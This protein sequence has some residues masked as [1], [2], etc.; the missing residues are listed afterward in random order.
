MIKFR[1]IAVAAYLALA[2]S[3]GAA[4]ATS[5]I[6]AGDRSTDPRILLGRP[7]HDDDLAIEAFHWLVSPQ[8]IHGVI[9][10]RHLGH[11]P[12]GLTDRWN[13]WGAYQWNIVIGGIHVLS[14]P[15]QEWTRNF[16]TETIIADH[17]T[18]TASYVGYLNPH[19]EWKNWAFSQN[20]SW[21][22]PVTLNNQPRHPWTTIDT[23]MSIQIVLDG[24]NAEKP[25][26]WDAFLAKNGQPPER[27]PQYRGRLC[28]TSA[29]VA[30]A[31]ELA[32][33]LLGPDGKALP[34]LR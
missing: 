34:M 15:Q 1:A 10:V 7:D 27:P 18:W 5:A 21:L 4:D 24:E 23:Q 11:G 28:A 26:E 6:L 16:F 25:D 19:S 30:G 14:N 22:D 3:L 9:R 31:D 8:E 32:K 13:S 20:T 29:A 17:G 12:V 33:H 2:A